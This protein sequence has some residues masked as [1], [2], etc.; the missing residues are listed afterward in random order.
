MNIDNRITVIINTCDAYQDVLRLFLCAL[1]EYWKDCNFRIIIN[2]ESAQYDFNDPKIHV[3]NYIKHNGIDKWGDRLRR[4]LESVD[5]EFVLVLYDDFVLEGR[6]D[7]EGINKAI[8]L[9]SSERE[10]SVVYLINTALPVEDKEDKLFLQIKNKSDFIINSAPSIW[11]KKDLMRYT[12]SNDNPWAWEV[13]GSYRTFN[14]S[15][16]FYTLN[17]RSNDIFPYNYKKGGAIYRGKWVKEVVDGK[18]KKY[19]LDID[20]GVRGFVNMDEVVKRGF[21]WKFNFIRT[22]FE[23]VGMKSLYFVFRYLKLKAKAK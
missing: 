23:M 21:L 18:F 8:E 4:V 1:N 2:T 9:L 13:F 19:N 10:A 20:P 3:A 7:S 5:S 14:C 16:V 15:N 22:G 12:G 6:V 11:R 17:P